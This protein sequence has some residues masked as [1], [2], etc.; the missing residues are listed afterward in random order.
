MR[1]LVITDTY[2]PLRSSGAIQLRD[3]SIEFVKQGHRVSVL[4]ASPDLDR[5]CFV[6]KL[7]GVEVIRIKK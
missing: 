2:P 6:D 1:Y 3:L 5:S 7:N 4:V